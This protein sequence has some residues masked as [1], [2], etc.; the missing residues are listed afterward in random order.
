MDFRITS[1]SVPGRK[2]AFSSR[3]I[4]RNI[5]FILLRFT[6]FPNLCGTRT[7]NR[8][9]AAPVKRGFSSQ[10]R[11]KKSPEKRCPSLT[12]FSISLL[13]VI[14][15][16]GRNLNEPAGVSDIHFLRNEFTTSSAPTSAQNS[17]SAG[18]FHSCPEPMNLFPAPDMGLKRLF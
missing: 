4:S 18:C 17:S 11:E 2:L 13:R 15:S 6:A 10:N 8:R 14:L 7:A 5:L 12:I 9:E 3:K 1:K 16:C